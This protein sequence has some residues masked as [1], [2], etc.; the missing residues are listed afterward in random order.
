MTNKAC[1]FLV[2]DDESNRLMYQEIL[3]QD[4]Y[5]VVTACDGGAAVH[6]YN[7]VHPDI[8]LVVLDVDMP[9][10]DGGSCLRAMRAV[11]PDLACLAITGHIDHPNLNDMIAQGI[12]GILR[13]PFSGEELKSWVSKVLPTK[14]VKQTMGDRRQTDYPFPDY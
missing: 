12:S 2:D 4:G 11:N 10:L 14:L 8:D 3:R 6:F 9:I 13:K 1:I 5:H 7:M